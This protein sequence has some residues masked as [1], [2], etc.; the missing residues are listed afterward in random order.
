MRCLTKTI[1]YH[2]GES[3]RLVFFSDVHDG[4][5]YFARNHFKRFLADSMNHPNAYCLSVG[6]NVDALVPADAKRFQISTVDEKFLVSEAPDEILDA[7][8]QDFVSLL[9]PYEGRI[10]GLG[11]GNHEQAIAKRYGFSIHRQICRD[12]GADDLGYSFLLLLKLTDPANRRTRSLTVYGIHGFGGGGRTEG[13]SVTKYSRLVQYYSADIFLSGHDHSPFSKKVA[14]I[15]INS[16]GK[17]QHRDLI[18]ANTGSFMKT[19]SEGSCPSWAETMGLPPRNL[20]GLVVDVIPDSH[21]W[22]STKIIE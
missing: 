16:K 21:G 4:S 8:A 9:K 3:V 7:Q 22:C 10:L 20:G 19:L 17:I 14:R 18:L 1:P 15:G 11:L 5:R 12:L 2:P 13:G 6:D